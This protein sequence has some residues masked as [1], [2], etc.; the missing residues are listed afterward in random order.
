MAGSW[1]RERANRSLLALLLPL[2]LLTLTA[3]GSTGSGNLLRR[4]AMSVHLLASM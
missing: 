4:P 3:C 2:G 1:R